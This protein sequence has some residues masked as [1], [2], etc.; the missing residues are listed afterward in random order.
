MINDSDSFLLAIDAIIENGSIS[1][2]R[3]GEEID[4]LIGNSS[5]PPSEDLLRL[6]HQIY[7]R[8]ELEIDQIKKIAVSVG[9]GSYTGIRVGISTALGIASASGCETIGISTLKALAY[10]SQDDSCVSLL[11][12]GGTEFIFQRFARNGVRFE[13]IGKPILIDI[14]SLLSLNDDQLLVDKKTYLAL[15][16]Q[17][18]AAEVLGRT[19]IVSDNFARL[20]ALAAACDN[21]SGANSLEPIYARKF[22]IR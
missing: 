9:P 22:G 13:E 16:R 15:K 7:S 8:N 12:I 10:E 5:S 18:A 6:I 20:V 14:D 11:S 17:E 19:V 2:W 3:S 21:K 1:L 4:N